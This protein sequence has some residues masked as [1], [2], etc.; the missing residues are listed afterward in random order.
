MR[1][2][3]FLDMDGV[4]VDTEAGVRALHGDETAKHVFGQ[5]G[6]MLP[7]AEIFR[8]VNED[9]WVD[10]PW[11][12]DGHEILHACEL[13]FGDGAVYICSKPT[14]L[15]HPATLVGKLRWIEKHCPKYLN[16]YVLTRQKWD[17]ASPDKWLVD[18]SEENCDRFAANGGHSVLV[19]RP[20]NRNAGLNTVDYII[21]NLFGDE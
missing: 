16:Q 2:I 15:A 11:S 7:E 4:L 6:V 8:W 9:W 20:W 10:L 21:D 13:A 5:Q 1:N 18:D 3:C 14:T 12:E 17:L 19:P